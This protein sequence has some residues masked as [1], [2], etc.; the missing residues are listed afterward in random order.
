MCV[1]FTFMT[2]G[3][4]SWGVLVMG[5]RVWDAWR[6]EMREMPSRNGCLFALGFSSGAEP[7]AMAGESMKLKLPKV[8]GIFLLILSCYAA[9]RL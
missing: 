8:Y 2:Y 9:S 1:M 7:E 5:W 3:R 6:R 4:A